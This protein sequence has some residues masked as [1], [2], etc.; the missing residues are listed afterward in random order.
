MVSVVKDAPM[1]IKYVR[2]EKNQR[3]GVV[4]AIG[5]N[6][7][8]FSLANKRDKFDKQYGI[9]LAVQRAFHWKPSIDDDIPHSVRDDFIEMVDRS[10]RY[11]K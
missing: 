9:H 3:R 6:E 11:F 5:A 2:D 4:V 1:L 8:G 10:M 7:I